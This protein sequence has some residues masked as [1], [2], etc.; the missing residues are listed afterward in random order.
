MTYD[1]IEKSGLELTSFELNTKLDSLNKGFESSV[2]P[3]NGVYYH[4][5]DGINYS[6][7]SFQSVFDSIKVMS[8]GTIVDGR[9]T[10]GL[11]ELSKHKI[12]DLYREQNKKQQAGF[13]AEI[14]GT[15]R[16]NIMAQLDGSGT[17]V[18]RVDDLSA[19][20][21]AELGFKKND[22]YVDKVRFKSDG[23]IEKVQTKF[24]GDSPSKCLSKLMSKKFE[25]YLTDVD[26]LGNPKVDKI[27]VPNEFYDQL[28]N[29]NIPQKRLELQKQLE[30]VTKNGKTEEIN[31]IQ[32]QLN[33]LDLLDEKLDKS[34]VST[35]EALS[36]RMNYKD[37]CAKEA[38]NQLKMVAKSAHNAGLES[39]KYAVGLTAAVSGVDN[40][41]KYR[42]GELTGTEAIE[43]TAKDTAIAGGVA[44]GTEIVTQLAGGSSVPAA[45]ITMGVESYGDVKDYA[46]G[47]IDGGELAYN[48]GENAARVVGGAV[49]GA[50]GA[51]V[52]A[53]AGT[54]M[55]PVGNAVGG[56]AGGMAGGAAGSAIAA[57]AY[58]DTVENVSD[59]IENV[60]GFIDGE[61]DGQELAYNLGENYA[62]AMGGVLAGDVAVQAYDVSVDFVSDRIDD[63]AEVSGD[64]IESI[65]E[66]AGDMIENTKDMANDVKNAAGDALDSAADKIGNVTGKL[67][68]SIGNIGR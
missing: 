9:K 50:M 23:K 18:K 20:K 58:E 63:V 45:V 32:K 15:E 28:K 54:V 19:V 66:T 25:K 33:N 57:K 61:I 5:V 51:A 52:G 48:L 16:E 44:Y 39:A 53:A 31:K 11:K 43:N 10:L 35:D 36:A 55:G 56:F 60:K 6:S 29:E 7:I 62:R 46:E 40:Y 37:F 30:S 2:K 42:S 59:S 8:D 64:V 49:G 27:E 17:V 12:N 1:S 24:V 4:N 38:A 41:Q 34:T 26:E 14:V 13:A 22:P 3:E 68:D 65:G 47:D 21:R 67:A